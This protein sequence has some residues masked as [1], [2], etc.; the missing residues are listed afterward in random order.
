M[1]IPEK[2][3]VHHVCVNGQKKALDSWSWSYRQCVLP[4]GCWD[5]NPGSLKEHPVLYTRESSYSLPPGGF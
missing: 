2:M 5:L 3:S 1:C 4:Y